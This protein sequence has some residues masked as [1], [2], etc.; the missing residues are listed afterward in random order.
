MFYNKLQAK[1]ENNPQ[2]F[3][4]QVKQYKLPIWEYDLRPHVNNQGIVD[5]VL[6]KKHLLKYK[7]NW[8]EAGDILHNWH[9]PMIPKS[10]NT[11]I[12]MAKLFDVA[13]E[14]VSK[15][16]G[17]TDKWQ[18]SYDFVLL[19][20]LLSIYNTDDF[21]AWHDH[22]VSE[23]SASYYAKVP[24]NSAGIVFENGKNT[25]EINVKE[26]MLLIFPGNA[27]H[28][29]NPSQHVGDRIVVTMNFWKDKIVY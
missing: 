2:Y 19:H 12:D 10:Q 1:I 23:F 29:T 26:G 21:I 8:E 13:T 14:K 22:G 18:K 17:T 24:E 15:I 20:Y 3:V 27:I 5:Y 9:S 6:S 28:K 16:W 25:L 11:N 4:Q 7:E